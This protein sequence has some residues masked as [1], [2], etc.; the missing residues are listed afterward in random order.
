[1]NEVRGV[2]SRSAC[3][4]HRVSWAKSHST[5]KVKGVDTLIGTQTILQPRSIVFFFLQIVLLQTPSHSAVHCWSRLTK[6]HGLFL[7]VTYWVV[8]DAAPNFEKE[9]LAVNAFDAYVQ[10]IERYTDKFDGQTKRYQGI[11]HSWEIPLRHRTSLFLRY[12]LLR[13]TV[14]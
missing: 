6:T 2:G 8:F 5:M 11:T 9:S 13:S 4:Y 14:K 10:W 3:L 1:M 7:W 12:A